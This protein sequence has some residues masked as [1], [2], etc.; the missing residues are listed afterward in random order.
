LK[1]RGINDR[2]LRAE[3]RHRILGC[4]EK[5][6]RE[7]V[8]PGE[9]AVDANRHAIPFIGADVAIQRIHVALGKV[10]FD[11]FEESI[12]DRLVDRTVGVAPVDILFARGFFDE[13]FV[14]GRTPGVRTRINDELPIA[15]KDT[16]ALPQCMLDELG[17]RKVLPQV[18]GLE[19]LRNGKNGRVPRC[20]RR[21]EFT[22]IYFLR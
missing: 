12:E 15:P 1:E 14:F 9:L 5:M 2:E 20:V 22:R 21:S 4:N 18:S 13:R 11:L 10:G 7:E 17:R 6:M 3:S 8:V 16:L 19:F